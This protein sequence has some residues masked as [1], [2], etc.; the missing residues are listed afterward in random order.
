MR[1]ALLIAAGCV[2]CLS[3]PALAYT[4]SVQFSKPNATYNAFL[5]DRNACLGAASHRNW[6]TAGV[7]GGPGG[8]GGSYA[9]PGMPTYNFSQFGRCMLARGYTLDPN[10]FHTVKFVHLQNGDYRLLE[11]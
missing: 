4:I 3:S 6:H 9:V 10:G 5:H 1:S 2:V 11:M 7:S 8:P